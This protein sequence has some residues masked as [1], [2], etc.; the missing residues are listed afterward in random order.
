MG[1]LVQSKHIMNVIQCFIPQRGNEHY[2]NKRGPD[3][4]TFFSLKANNGQGAL[5]L[6]NGIV[7][8]FIGYTLRN[9]LKRDLTIE[10]YFALLKENISSS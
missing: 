7:N 4:E 9:M 5:L 2:L 6:Y 1:G 8:E 10:N 3:N